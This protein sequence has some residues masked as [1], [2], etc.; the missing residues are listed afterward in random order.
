MEK[1]DVCTDVPKVRGDEGNGEDM[2][3]LF[4]A[5]IM[6]IWNE[7]LFL[8]STEKNHWVKKNHLHAKIFE[9]KVY[10]INE[11]YLVVP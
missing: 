10:L 3:P 9:T 7:L 8:V 2:A 5:Y 11:V 1:N 4:R 6:G